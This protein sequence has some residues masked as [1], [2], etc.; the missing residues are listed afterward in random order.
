[1]SVKV[2]D[3]ACT[4]TFPASVKDTFKHKYPEETT[5][6]TVVTDSLAHFELPNDGTTRYYLYFDGAEVPGAATLGSLLTTD[7]GHGNGNGQGSGSGN[8]GE[9]KLALGLRCETVSG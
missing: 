4:I 9:Q 3:I 5:A 8:Q 2:K 1:V 7:S 6:Q